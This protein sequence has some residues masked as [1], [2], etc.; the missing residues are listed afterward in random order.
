MDLFAK[1]RTSRD[2][3]LAVWPSAICE[4][5]LAQDKGSRLLVSGYRIVVEGDGSTPRSLLGSGRTANEA[6]HAAKIKV[7]AAQPVFGS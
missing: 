4:Q 7:R 5:A 6:W 2:E 1:Q 3:V